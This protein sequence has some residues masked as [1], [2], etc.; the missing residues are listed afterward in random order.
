MAKFSFYASRSEEEDGLR[1]KREEEKSQGGLWSR[2]GSGGEEGQGVVFSQG[3]TD[4][5]VFDFQTLK[6]SSPVTL[7]SCQHAKRTF[8]KIFRAQF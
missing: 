3:D 2:R 4:I 8:L 7:P 1:G 5:N 6:F